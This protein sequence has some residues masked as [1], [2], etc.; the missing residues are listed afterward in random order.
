MAKSK[1]PD[2]PT[3]AGIRWISGATTRVGGITQAWFTDQG[4]LRLEIDCDYQ[5]VSHYTVTFNYQDMTDLSKYTG[6]WSSNDASHSSNDVSVQL[7]ATGPCVY[8]LA[9]TWTEHRERWDWETTSEIMI[10]QR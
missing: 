9:G 5:E 8:R 3:T 4:I 2:G 1:R 7:T 10:S 6:K